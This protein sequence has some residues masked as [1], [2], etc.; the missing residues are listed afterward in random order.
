MASSGRK[1]WQTKFALPQAVALSL[2]LEDY[3]K[4]ER[5]YLTSGGTLELSEEQKQDG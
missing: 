5:I 2:E 1:E 4:I 3:G